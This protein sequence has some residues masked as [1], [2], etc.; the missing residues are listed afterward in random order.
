MSGRSSFAVPTNVTPKNGQVLVFNDDNEAPISFTNNTDA[1]SFVGLL[2]NDALIPNSSYPP[3]SSMWKFF[4]MARPVITHN[5]G[6]NITLT[7]E[8]YI[9][10]RVYD[11]DLGQWVKIYYL[12]DQ[13]E[14]LQRYYEGKHYIYEL[15]MFS[16]YPSPIAGGY[17]LRPNN[18]VKFS[19]GKIQSVLSETELMIEPTGWRLLPPQYWNESYIQDGVLHKGGLS[20]YPDVGKYLVRANY[21]EIY[22]KQ[23]MIIEARADGY[24]KLFEPITP[25]K[26]H[27]TSDGA[28][29]IIPQLTPQM[30]YTLYWN[31]ITSSGSSGEGSYDF[32]IRHKIN[33]SSYA[34]PVPGSFR[35]IST[36]EHPDDIGMEKYRFRVYQLFG[37][38]NVE[39]ESY[40]NGEIQSSRDESDD[41][42]GADYKHIPIEKNIEADLKYK[43]IIIGSKTQSGRISSGQWGEIVDYDKHS[44]LITLKNELNI[45]PA[46]GQ[47]YTI[48]LC[49]RLLIADSGDCYSYHLAYN[50]PVYV[51][52]N[53][54]QIETIVTSYEKQVSDT[55]INIMYPEPEND[56]DYGQV[57][58]ECSFEVNPVN[59]TVDLTF[60]ESLK[61]DER[62]FGLYRR[63]TVGEGEMENP[64]EYIGFMRGGNTFVDHLAANNTSY[65]YL[66]SRVVTYVPHSFDNPGYDPLHEYDYVPA[67]EYKAHAFENAVQTKWDGWSITAIYPCENDY[68]SD[69]IQNHREDNGYL[70][71]FQGYY[72]DTICNF[73]CT[74]TPYKVGD[75]WTFYS[76]IDSGEIVSNLGR[77]VHVGTSTYPSVTGTNN[78]YQSGTFS[79]D[80]VTLDCTSEKIYDNIEKVRAWLDFITDDCLFILK[81]DKGDVWIVAISDNP[82]RSYDESVDDI[83]TKVSYSWTEVDSPNNIQIVEY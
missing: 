47:R 53:K 56:Y 31:H 15:T 18:S 50:F 21:I 73:V 40:I 38:T 7:L 29:V 36:Y 16:C 60:S 23:A 27:D 1:M 52:G 9:T 77:T 22:G 33:S 20:T 30:P 58:G 64:W 39:N 83:I 62:F 13:G 19:S 12:N 26:L 55:C 79:T 46:P 5:R 66:I 69:T 80:V 75:T 51:L 65:D 57:N 25:I 3:E 35:C 42:I 67:N 28:E 49:D 17:T 63:E 70:Q 59:Q 45:F 41:N 6:D 81:S 14:R 72:K 74:K 43:R 37:D 54:Y 82:S 24:I 68:L 2:V 48:E 76:A 71:E 11:F 10:E 34:N 44:G 61:S 78:K 8:K 4:N 32:Y